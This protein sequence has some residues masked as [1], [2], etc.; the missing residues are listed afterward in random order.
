MSGAAGC[1]PI[2][3]DRDAVVSCRMPQIGLGRNSRQWALEA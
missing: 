1:E 3:N 2:R